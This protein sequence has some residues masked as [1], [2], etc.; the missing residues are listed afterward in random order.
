MSNLNVND[1]FFLPLAIPYLPFRYKDKIL[2]IFLTHKE[3]ISK[4]SD[5]K[6]PEFWEG[7]LCY[8]KEDVD[9]SKILYPGKFLDIKEL[10][11]EEINILNEYLPIE[12]ETI[13]LWCNKIAVPA[14][15]DQKVYDQETDFRFRFVLIQEDPS[16]FI[17]YENRSKYIDL[18][19]DANVFA[20]N[21]YSCKHGATVPNGKKVLGI[22]RGKINNYN[23]FLNLIEMSYNKYNK[24]VIEKNNI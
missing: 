22:I 15:M 18:P 20:F 24:F 10:L 9:E 12:V 6:I 17:K 19:P 14:H 3:S 7:M 13:S 11:I 16:F 21:N 2:D 23:K 5:S 1:V 8:K 4:P